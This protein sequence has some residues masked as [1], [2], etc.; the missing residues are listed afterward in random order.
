[1]VYPL[2]SFRHTGGRRRVAI[3]SQHFN[4]IDQHRV[5][6]CRFQTSIVD[7]R[8]YWASPPTC[9]EAVK[10][11]VPFKSLTT[12][13]QTATHRDAC[14]KN[15]YIGSK[16]NRC[17]RSARLLRTRCVISSICQKRVIDVQ[18]P[19]FVPRSSVAQSL[20]ARCD[21]AVLWLLRTVDD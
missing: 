15:I 2:Y 16:L 4:A 19:K 7:R 10:S 12:F 6:R 11:N 13:A 20:R 3:V 14:S 5:T 18:L 21:L 1:M 17:R 8:R 9:V